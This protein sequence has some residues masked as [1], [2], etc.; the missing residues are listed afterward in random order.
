MSML[1]EDIAQCRVP[2]LH[3][4]F[5]FC[6]LSEAAIVTLARAVERNQTLKGFSCFQ[7][8]CNFRD[9]EYDGS[10]PCDQA[11]KQAI[12]RT[13]APIEIW[14]NYQL[15]DDV[16]KDRAVAKTMLPAQPLLASPVTKALMPP[17]RS[18]S[19]V[20]KA[21]PSATSVTKTTIPPFLVQLFKDISLS[22]EERQTYQKLFMDDAIT[23]IGTLMAFDVGSLRSL[24]VKAGHA[25]QILTTDQE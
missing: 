3:V 19:P 23:D 24:G 2:G 6:N 16:K 13:R 17:Q 14:N 8:P 21:P 5:A 18:Q 11:V 7:N 1:A 10:A 22:D 20:T 4:R 15:P 25:A 9:G 12:I